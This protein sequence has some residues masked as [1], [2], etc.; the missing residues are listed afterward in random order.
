MKHSVHFSAVMLLSLAL[1]SGPAYARGRVYDGKDNDPTTYSFN[2]GSKIRPLKGPRGYQLLRENVAVDYGLHYT[3]LADG[4][5]VCSLE[6][7]W[8]LG[9]GGDHPRLLPKGT[10]LTNWD[11]V[12]VENGWVAIDPETGRFKFATENKIDSPTRTKLVNRITLGNLTAWQIEVK[13]GFTFMATE[14]ETHGCLIMD[15]TNPDRLQYAGHVLTPGY[16][17]QLVV[18]KDHV[19]TFA[20]GHFSIGD[21]RDLKNHNPKYIKQQP[22]PDYGGRVKCAWDPKRNFLFVRRGIQISVYDVKDEDDPVLVKVLPLS[23]YGI[24]V[25]GD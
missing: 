11:D 7:A 8:K 25:D 12:K 17:M 19:Y 15:A 5:D 10:D 2:R 1:L 4:V 14:E 13:D 20:G 23:G 21:I 6:Y 24:A 16:I 18:L 9:F 22:M 3:I